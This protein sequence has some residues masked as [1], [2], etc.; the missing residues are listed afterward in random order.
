MTGKELS[1]KVK[2][3]ISKVIIGKEDIITQLNRMSINRAH[4]FPE[5][6]DVTAHIKNRYWEHY[7]FCIYKFPTFQKQHL[8]PS[9][10]FL[11]DLIILFRPSA[12]SQNADGLFFV[13]SGTLLLF[14]IRCISYIYVISWFA[15]SA[16][17]FLLLLK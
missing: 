3:N 1:Q 8:N 7:Y 15:T 11:L 10:C 14:L 16:V 2:S 17:P 6:Q 4:L 5:I 13:Y 12:F 9:L